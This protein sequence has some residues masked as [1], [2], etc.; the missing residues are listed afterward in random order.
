MVSMR[1]RTEIRP[2]E[3]GNRVK[4]MDEIKHLCRN[5]IEGSIAAL[6]R[7]RP[8]PCSSMA[9]R[10]FLRGD[11][12]GKI[13]ETLYEGSMVGA[14]PVVFAVWGYCIAKADRAGVVI[15]NP[16]LL[17]PIIGTSRREIEQAIEYLE[18]PDERSKNPEHEGRRLV[19]MSGFAYSVVSHAIYRN[20]KTSGERNEYMREYMRK[21]RGGGGVNMLTKLTN[22]NPVSVSV[23]DSVSNGERVQG[24]G[25]AKPPKEDAD[26][27]AW[28]HAYPKKTGKLAAEASW[29][30]M[31]SR[32]P[33]LA[34]MVDKLTAQKSSTKWMDEGGRYIPNPATYLNQG[35]WM[36][37]I[38]AE[39][40]LQSKGAVLHTGDPAY[41]W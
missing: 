3:H 25:K 13:F 36:D 27:S 29:R 35:R 6:S 24:K 18:S 9:L 11:M 20:I 7:G 40:K 16:A 30:K 23:S 37:G 10:L 28:W 5:A 41:A 26:F 19:N 8:Y 17:A 14:G 31:K 33:P 34:E 39:V 2:A 21:R 38:E 12:Y 4:Q 1:V 15:L 22:A 32:L